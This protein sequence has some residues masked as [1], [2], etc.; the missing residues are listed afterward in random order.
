MMRTLQQWLAGLVLCL[1]WFGAASAQERITDFFSDVA[2]QANGD[3]TVTETI[4]VLAE[5]KRIQ[6]GVL[7]DFPTT[8]RRDDGSRVKV[9]FDVRYVWR[10]GRPEV[11][12]TERLAN[13]VRL[14][15]GDPY[16]LLEPGS[17][18]YQIQY[19]TSRQI[20]FFPDF[21]ELYW[22]ATG[23][24]WAF[25]IDRARARI[26]LP[27][28]VPFDR[29]ALYTGP[30]GA[31]DKNAR[32]VQQIP[33]QITLETTAP[34][35]VNEGLTVAASWRKGVVQAP[36]VTEVWLLGL[37]DNLFIAVAAIGFVLLSAY[38]L[39][40]YRRR[41]RRSTAVVVPLYE[42]PSGM[43]AP[44]VRY[45]AR[46][47]MD[48]RVFVVALLE[49][50]SLRLVRMTK[51][52]EHTRF[53]RAGQASRAVPEGALLEAILHKLFRKDQAFTR[54]GLQG[55]RFEDAEDAMKAFLQKKYGERLFATTNQ[56]A[57]TGRNYWFLYALLTIA[58]GWLQDS[59]RMGEPI[60]GLLF[61]VP[62]VWGLAATIRAWRRKRVSAVILIFVAV[63][64]VPMLLSSLAALGRS[65]ALVPLDTVA[66]LLVLAMLAV[67]TWAYD[68]LPTYTEEG[69]QVMDKINGFKKYLTLAEGPRLQALVSP[70][71]K[72][73]VYE[74]FLPYAVSLDVGKQ[75]AAGF[76]GMFAGVAGMA[77]LDA[78]QQRYGGHDLFSSD[79]DRV[80]RDIGQE[81]TQVQSVAASSSS[82][83]GTSS[84]YS[85]S[86]SDSSSSGSSGSGSSGGGGGGGGGDGW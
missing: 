19:R 22:N 77:A 31:R 55:T 8:Y 39:L 13:G 10:D 28:Q 36:P 86:S 20:G 12:Q 15:I 30:A 58:A 70:T 16:T 9:D 62:A 26:T 17:H 57:R 79:P 51:K 18:E 63:F 64:L 78:M 7:R 23:T 33:G 43:T 42:P 44:E 48:S 45:V 74:R 71:D 46:Q 53:E 47:G 56:A 25:A 61:G 50:V 76:A 52:G 66:A 32:V 85:G 37:R 65:L 11:F 6:R 38:Y 24:G 21:D 80:A 60:F 69:H 35:A 2:V 5:G 72:L 82:S 83:P 29:S 68:F 73:E 59:A 81:V 84:S 67:T 34:L 54:D 3:L 1:G 14:R 75:W 49:L 41:R 27:A 40:A 4:T